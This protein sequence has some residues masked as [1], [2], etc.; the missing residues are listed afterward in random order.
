MLADILDL[1]RRTFAYMDGLVHPPS[2][3]HHL[4][5]DKLR[6]QA[7]LAEIWSSGSPLLASMILTP[8]RHALYVGKLCVDERSRG[9]GLSRMMLAHATVRAI[10]LK[11]PALELETRIELRDNHAAFQ[12]MGFVEVARTSH[13]GFD[14]PTALTFRRKV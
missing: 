13:Q 7:N 12:V 14:H 6:T 8:K 10:A 4:T 5:L 11:L 9:K 2:S 1:T 3:I